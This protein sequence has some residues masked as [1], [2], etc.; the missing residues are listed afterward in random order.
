[1]A[2]KAIAELSREE[3]EGREKDLRETLARLH[4]KRHAQRLEKPSELK[5][6]KKDL[7]RVLTALRQRKGPT[8]G[9]RGA[10]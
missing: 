9:A 1:M 5:A 3:L 10:K 8:R 6:A 7:A 4:M 2:E